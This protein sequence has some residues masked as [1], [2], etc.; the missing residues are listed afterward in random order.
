[1]C[2]SNQRRQNAGLRAALSR[3]RRIMAADVHDS[4]AQNLTFAKMRLPLL[5]DAIEAGDAQLALAFLEDVRETLGEAHG[6]LRAVVTRMRS[7]ADPQG[8]AG[9][10]EALAARFRARSGIAL[11]LANHVPALRLPAPAQAELFHIVQEAL[12]NVERHS[13]ARHSWLTLEPQAGRLEVR[14]E[15]D[16]LGGAER[17]A[18]C[19]GH[20]GLAIMRERA[21]RIGGEI[22]IGPRPAGGTSVRCTLPQPAGALA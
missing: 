5:R 17:L 15:D 12:A 13:R 2:P 9:A 4:V 19:T 22:W 20:H 1:M 10:F 11:E 21:R 16:G 14:V 18:A 3:E 6:N 8:L 7:R